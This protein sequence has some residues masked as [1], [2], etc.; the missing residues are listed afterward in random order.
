MADNRGLDTLNARLA[1]IGIDAQF[2][3]LPNIDYV[4]S[5]L[6][7]GE[8]YKG[9]LHKAD[10][11]W[12]DGQDLDPLLEQSDYPTLC[13]DSAARVVAANKLSAQQVAVIILSDPS[14]SIAVT[15]Q[16]YFS[17]SI[18]NNLGVALTRGEKL[19]AE[20]N[21]AVLIIAAN[22]NADSNIKQDQASISFSDD[23][24]GYAQH[25]GVV[26]VLLS[27]ADF[28]AANGCYSYA[29]LHSAACS[30]NTAEQMFASGADT[31]GKMRATIERSLRA[32]KISAEM[33]DSV[34]VSAL[35]APALCILETN[36]LLYAYS[37]GQKL[38]TAISC[39]KSVL[40]DNGALSQLLGLLNSVFVLQQRY[41]A[42]IKDWAKPS[43][44]KLQAWS[45][46]PFY[47]FN[48][49]TPA[50]PNANGSPRYV[51]YSCLS[52][53]HY[54]HII[55]QENNDKLVHSNGFNAC[56]DLTLFVL[57][58]N[59]QVGL[60][61]QLQRLSADI[62]GGNFKA[63]AKQYFKGFSESQNK[64]FKMVL[65]AESP[66]QLIKEITLALTGIKHAFTN[67]THWKTPKGSYFSATPLLTKHNI[68][69]LYPGI[70]A[71]YVGLGQDLFHLFP[72]IY[73]NVVSLA[74]NIGS[75]LKEQLIYPRSVTR[76]D[77]RELKQLN[78]SLRSRLADIAEC[79]VGFAC[80]FSQIF[81]QV[82]NIKA[83]FAA[84]YSMGEISMY[85]GLGCWHKPGLM[86]ARL[87]DSDTFNHRLSGELRALRERWNL[88]DVSDGTVERIWETY[89]IRGSFDEVSKA[90][91]KGE[92]VYVTLINT[93]DSLTIGG[94]PKDCLQ[95]I[96]RLGVRAVPLN[97]GN[98]I[99]SEVAYT[100]YQ[101]MQNLYTMA[102]SE[103][104]NTKMYS[105]SCYLPIPQHPKAIALS[106]A[107][108]LCEPV[109][110]PRLINTLH[111]KG[112][113]VFIE[114]GAGTSLSGWTNK[115]LKRPATSDKT[116][117]DFLT[118]P[119]NAKGCDDQLSYA[120]L[121]AKLVSAGI[122]INLSSFFY[123][124]IIQPVCTF[125]GKAC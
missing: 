20:F 124:S 62:S 100:E 125:S 16:E 111:D 12:V 106:I 39:S 15:L 112:A 81:A 99:H 68:A 64:A 74:D 43:F 82:F 19:I 118:V 113:E 71:T 41:R 32:A 116:A 18:V 67:N 53:D 34:E 80:V 21:V 17:C 84:G 79:G 51:A 122:D 50:F 72:E 96:K 47:F 93:A 103:R 13:R 69:F 61:V 48:K 98:A 56:A 58:E 119:V 108:C 66:E 6:Y 3:G 45:E 87:A 83:D 11:Y 35:K 115:I 22:L 90:I 104:I 7:K 107:K 70:G 114:M 110:F 37:H 52:Q 4:E 92:R 109:D 28:A 55:L 101:A 23:F 65:L 38:N 59:N 121:A 91:E 54:A 46:S 25:N 97:I 9:E 95:V 88:P 29:T 44:E 89:S 49:A 14:E 31:A 86:S 76:L 117:A 27:A 57:A 1:I 102:V 94:Y 5:A 60:T 33:I 105:S 10:L 40:G 26:S 75:T 77:F 8:R 120:R 24:S 30:A 85:A 78:L 73:S 63:L 42:G 2:E 36:A 123:G